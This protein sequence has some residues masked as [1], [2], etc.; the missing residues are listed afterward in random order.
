MIHHSICKKISLR[1]KQCNAFL[2]SAGLAF[3]KNMFHL[4]A[5]IILN[6]YARDYKKRCAQ[7]I[8]S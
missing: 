8:K 2:K 1:N 6:E 4:E 3:F 5:S 7:A